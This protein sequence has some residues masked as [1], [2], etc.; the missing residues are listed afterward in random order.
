MKLVIGLGNPGRR[1]QRTR[2]NIGFMTIDV[3][4]RKHSIFVRSRRAKCLVGEGEVSGERVVLAKPMTFMN[5]S[6]K[7]VSAL[8]SCYNA[9]PADMIVLVDDVNLPLGRIRIRMRGS[10]GGHKGLESIISEIGTEDFPRIRIGIGAPRPGRDMV[11]YVLSRFTRLEM[12]TVRTSIDKAVLALETMICEGM[13]RAMNL[14]NAP[15]GD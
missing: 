3:L 13:E 1:Y 15:S 6:G 4:A 5:L 10:A 8:L 9:S 12:P 14:F 11:D 7:A 2:H